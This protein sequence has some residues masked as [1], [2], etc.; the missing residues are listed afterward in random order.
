MSGNFP[1]SYPSHWDGPR[2]GLFLHW[3]LYSLTGW[4]EQVQGRLGIPREEYEQLARRFCPLQFDPDRWV[5][6]AQAAGMRYIVFTAKHHD[7][8]C[9]WHT[10]AAASYGE[11]PF[12]VEQTP[13]G[14]D[15]VR[16]L[17]DACRRHKMDFCIYYSIPDWHHPNAYNS[18]STH[19]MPPAPGDRPDMERY[20]QYI[21]CQVS[22][23]CT[24]YGRIHSWFWD[25]P[26]HLEDPS[27]NQML[28]RLQPGI[29]INDRGFSKGDYSTPERSIPE[30]TGFSTPTEAC[31]SVGRESWGYRCHEDYFSARQLLLAADQ[32]LSM[33]GNYLLNVGPKADGSIPEPAE[34]LLRRLGR[35]YQRVGQ[36]YGGRIL[37]RFSGPERIL[38]QDIG[39]KNVLYLHFPG[40]L[41]ASGVAIP[42][43]TPLAPET[44]PEEGAA[45]ERL[46]QQAREE[47]EE[48]SGSRGPACRD[49]PREV[50]LLNGPEGAGRLCWALEKMPSHY[51]KLTG[52]PLLASL[53][54]W[55]IPVDQLESE[56]VVLRLTMPEN[57]TP[58][59]TMG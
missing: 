6:L 17:S 47:K 21:K 56:A 3:G 34:A 57:W 58:Q 13:Y 59:E 2:L 4:Q 12:S 15:I 33:G 29:L 38:L 48:L 44:E 10:R 22:E 26:P 52:T 19:Q 42:G 45:L 39:R 43:W 9:M 16:E 46:V 25:I 5:E 53:H 11:R 7:G 18:L 31:Q 23:L 27:L 14:K 28:R 54:I 50:A 41:T 32:T 51:N 49:L 24:G 55:G 1:A 30:G 8:F 20:I 35:W 40:G 36:S 37:S